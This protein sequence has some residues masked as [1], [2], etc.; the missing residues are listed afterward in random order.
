M[1]TIDE[2]Y[3]EV[4]TDE[5]LMQEYKA[6][7][8]NGTAAEFLR[9]H[10]CAASEDEVN[11][12]LA[13]HGISGEP[14]GVLSDDELDDVAAGGICGGPEYYNGYQVVTPDAKCKK[15]VCRSCGG[16]LRS[17]G[18]GSSG[19]LCSGCRNRVNCGNCNNM[20]SY[21]MKCVCRL[22]KQ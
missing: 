5:A 8:E 4:K 2:L 19:Y 7:R 13:A 15:F 11:A 6:A 21:G 17:Q 1:K 20:M 10:E 22:Y 16:G 3:S 12:F 18:M 14:H 9:A